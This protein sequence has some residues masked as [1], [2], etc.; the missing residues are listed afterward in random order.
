[1]LTYFRG[2]SV[3]ELRIFWCGYY[4]VLQWVYVEQ[5]CR[6]N[7]V[8]LTSEY[9]IYIYN[10]SMSS[11]YICAIEE[12]KYSFI[13]LYKMYLFIYT[14][15]GWMS[16]VGIYFMHISHLWDLYLYSDTLRD[17]LKLGIP[18]WGFPY[19]LSPCGRPKKHE[20]NI[21]RTNCPL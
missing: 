6:I 16:V 19:N 1:M 17:P 14:L 20:Q 15:Q 11:R 5:L 21:T 18:V 4:F 13:H 2:F 12:R 8:A 10:I 3:N 7:C 9:N